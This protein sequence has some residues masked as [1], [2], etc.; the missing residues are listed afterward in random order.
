MK[1]LLESTKN[2]DEIVLFRV[3]AGKTVGY[4]HI[5][6]CLSL[7]HAMRE[8][9][10]RCV[11]VA[12]D[13]VPKDVVTKNG[14]DFVS[15]VCGTEDMLQELG[16]MTQLMD[17]LCPCLI[18][19]DSYRV[20]HQYL[21]TMRSMGRLVYIDDVRAFPYPCDVL[22]NYNIYGSQW[23]EDYQKEQAPF[24]STLLLGTQYAPLR[25]EFA[26]C[27]CRTI[28]QSVKK[29]LVSTG[30]ADVQNVTQRILDLLRDS[31]QL[32]G[33]EFHFLVGALNPYRVQIETTAVEMKNVKLH[34]EANNISEL[35]QMCD[36][37]IS[38]A[39]STL[40]ELCAC[41]T[42]TITYILADNQ[43]PG[44]RVFAEKKL[45]LFA[46]DCGHEQFECNLLKCMS[47]L[48]ESYEMRR[49][50]SVQMQN[51]VDGFGADRLAKELLEISVAHTLK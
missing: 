12:S 20:T 23:A 11:F 25:K 51:K 6:R 10:M 37:A 50:I 45:M 33:I 13:S 36:V 31:P 35:M 30:G 3:D 24:G 21:Q 5:M 40:Y 22:V 39:G 44:A 27:A 47:E 15:L 18:V 42:P 29:V 26:S 28:A 32:S 43:I 41:G 38:A 4:G 14:F 34:V 16:K 1:A 2:S 8:M 49:N 46:G 48:M 9:G 19:V 7:A 17:E